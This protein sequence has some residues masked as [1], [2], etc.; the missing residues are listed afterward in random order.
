MSLDLIA[1]TSPSPELLKALTSLLQASNRPDEK[2]LITSAHLHATSEILGTVAWPIVILAAIFLFR[3][4][5]RDL[6]KRTRRLGIAGNS[7][8]A[9]E[10]ID[11]KVESSAVEVLKSPDPLPS[12]TVSSGEV[13][14]SVEVANLSQEAQPE[15]IRAKIEQISGEYDD[16]RAN[17]PSGG[18]RTRQM[19]AIMAKMRTLG[20]AAFPYR[21]ELINHP[22]AGHRLFA[23]AA[24][25]MLPDY[26]LVDW[27][28]ETTK[29]EAPYV[30]YQAL[31]ALLIAVRNA[32]PQVVT[33]LRRAIR[34]AKMN[35]SQDGPDTSRWQLANMIEHEL[36]QIPDRS[37]N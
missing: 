7:I 36:S 17:M 11:A 26:D 20:R 5:M 24:L 35:L 27:L 19:G 1:Q 14:R 37:D 8:E 31:N 3:I 18:A 23:V 16:V 6:I 12:A 32:G 9:E 28:A 15:A 29:T 10:K 30:Q 21:L 34:N 2:T 4:E 25:Q 33:R 22:S 13:R